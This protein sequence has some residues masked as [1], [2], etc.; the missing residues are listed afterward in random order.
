MLDR[1]VKKRI[2]PP[3]DRVRLDTCCY[4]NTPNADFVVSKHPETDQIIIG[5]GFSGHSFKFGPLIGQILAELAADGDCLLPEYQRL[6]PRFD[7][8]RAT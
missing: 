5:A 8:M 6:R 7:L 2:A 4:T 3:V 1:F